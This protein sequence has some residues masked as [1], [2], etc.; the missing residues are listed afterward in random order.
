MATEHF[1]IQRS[2]GEN[3]FFSQEAESNTKRW[4]FFQ[5]NNVLKVIQ[6]IAI[7]PPPVPGLSDVAIVFAG[8]SP[9]LYQACF[10]FSVHDG[11]DASHIMAKTKQIKSLRGSRYAL[12]LCLSAHVQQ[13]VYTSQGPPHANLQHS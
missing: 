4:L 6:A 3:A 12:V 9:L 13:T 1:S 10:L 11:F 7:R 5:E 2:V 8:V